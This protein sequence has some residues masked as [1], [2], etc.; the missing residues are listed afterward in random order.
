MPQLNLMLACTSAMI[1]VLLLIVFRQPWLPPLGRHLAQA[2]GLL[3]SGISFGIGLYGFLR[4]DRRFL[5]GLLFGG[6]CFV[7]WFGLVCQGV[8]R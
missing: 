6:T 3:G 1:L 2:A 5:T 8:F 4:Y 7:F